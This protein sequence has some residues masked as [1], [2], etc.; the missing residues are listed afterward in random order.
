MKES[1]ATKAAKLLSAL[2]NPKNKVRGDAEYYSRLASMRRNPGRRPNES[3]QT[4][5]TNA[6][7]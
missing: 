2:A 4:A 6:A 5:A 3:G 1:Q 7:K